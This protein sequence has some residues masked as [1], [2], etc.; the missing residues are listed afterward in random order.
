MLE[1]WLLFGVFPEHIVFES[2]IQRISRITLVMVSVFDL[3]RKFS[4]ARI[5][6]FKC[7][8]PMPFGNVEKECKK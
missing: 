8:L 3:G 4:F 5:I 6:L 2:W 1:R 7:F